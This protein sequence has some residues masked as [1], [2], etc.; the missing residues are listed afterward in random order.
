M[1][2]KQMHILQVSTFDFAGGAEKVAWNLFRAYRKRRHDSWLAVGFKR[3]NERGVLPIP[4]EEHRSCWA[5]TWN[6]IANKPLPLIG[7]VRGTYRLRKL[8]YWISE[9]KRHWE[10]RKGYEDFNFPGTWQLLNLY[11]ELPDI[12][13]CHNLHGNYFD[14]R[15]ITWLS[16]QVPIVLTLHDAWLLS[17]H[18]AH[19]FNCERWKIGCGKCPDVTIYPAIRRDAT[20][21]NWRRKKEIYENSK[22]YVVTPSKWL[23][24]KVE[25]S[26][27]LPAIIESKVIPNGVDLSVFHPADRQ[28]VRES[29]GIPPDAKVVLFAANGIRRNIW[30]DYQTMRDAISRVG[31]LLHGKRIKF[32]ALGEDAPPE[33]I[34]DVEVGFVPYQKESEAVACY[35]QA[36]DVYVHAA[37]A[38]TFPNTV[39]EALA[40]GTP[41]VATAVGGIPEQIEDG[42]TGFLVPPGNADAMALRIVQLFERVDVRQKMGVQAA[43]SA[44]TSFDV[45]RQ[46]EDYL[47]WYK[48]I[49]FSCA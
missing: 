41:I 14:L 17:G 29:I 42:V 10:T 35:Y 11:S 39:L 1:V 26:I 13:H 27:L 43:I 2:K 23:M 21:S 24:Q 28:S 18:C 49:L 30:K 37:R 4:N 6:A 22:F 33:R 44:R 12:I 25:Q 36:A 5:R 45:D 47:E 40:C 9:F 3:S 48:K 7:N 19:S 20:A 38:D 8:L 32:I 15:A 34:G 31:D 46:V 16:K